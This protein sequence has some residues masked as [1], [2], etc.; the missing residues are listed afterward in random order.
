MF[1]VIEKNSQ[2]CTDKLDTITIVNFWAIESQ[3]DSGVFFLKIQFI[4]HLTFL[5]FLDHIIFYCNLEDLRSVH[6]FTCLTILEWPQNS[7][8]Q[9]GSKHTTMLIIAREDYP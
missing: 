3:D 4:L 8:V 5:F 6:R 2:I 1:T 9:D 7:L